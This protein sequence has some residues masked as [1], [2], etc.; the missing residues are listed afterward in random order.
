VKE[1]YYWVTKEEREEGAVEWKKNWEGKWWPKAT[2][3]SWLASRG[4][5]LTWDN[6]QKRG[7]YGPSMCSLC[8]KEN[9]TQ[10]HLLNKC[11]YARC[12]WEEI[13][14]LFGKTKRDPDNI[15]NTLIQWGKWNFQRKVARR[16]WNLAVGFVIWS[17]WRE[18]N[19]RIFRDKS[20]QESRIWDEICR[21]IKE[22]VL[23]K[24]WDEEDR[25]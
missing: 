6:I 24:I 23:S 16:I 3:F 19:R 13:R 7:M 12:L 25:K 4:R 1:P 9:E 17:I 10:E 2:I 15:R 14:V 21:S 20:C 22:T 8:I 11:P 5:I 18:R